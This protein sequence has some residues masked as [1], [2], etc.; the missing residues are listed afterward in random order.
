MAGR[1][2]GRSASLAALLSEPGKQP[3][4]NLLRAT[5][6][7]PVIQEQFDLGRF[8]GMIS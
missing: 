5:G 7:I 3:E 4:D 8:R 6:N 1:T 2:K